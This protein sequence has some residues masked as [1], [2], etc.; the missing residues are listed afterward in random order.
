MSFWS[1]EPIKVVSLKTIQGSRSYKELTHCFVRTRQKD[2]SQWIDHAHWTE[3]LNNKILIHTNISQPIRLAY[4]H[5]SPLARQGCQL[6][7]LVRLGE[8]EGGVRPQHKLRLLE[9]RRDHEHLV[10][11]TTSSTY[12]L[13]LL[14]KIL[15][16]R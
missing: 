7:H 9:V 14:N 8:R 4:L 1:H 16:E 10:K 5:E 12:D 13:N 11:D 15:K 3:T 6:G 2:N